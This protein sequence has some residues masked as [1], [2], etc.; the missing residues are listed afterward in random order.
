MD[1]YLTTPGRPKFESMTVGLVALRMTGDNS[2]RLIHRE[3]DIE[4]GVVAGQIRRVYGSGMYWDRLDRPGE[5]EF[6]D[7]FVEWDRWKLARGILGRNPSQQEMDIITDTIQWLGTPVGTAFVTRGL[8][9][10]RERN[11]TPGTTEF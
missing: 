4:Y 6:I 5:K 9:R 2:A 11:I 10:A 7:T 3:Q 1:W 8:Q